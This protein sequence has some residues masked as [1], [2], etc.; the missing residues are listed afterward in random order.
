MIAAQNR[1]FLQHDLHLIGTTLSDNELRDLL[2]LI[3]ANSGRLQDWSGTL[4]L[5]KGS[6]T[7]EESLCGELICDKLI[8]HFKHILRSLQQNALELIIRHYFN[9]IEA[10]FLHSHL[11]WQ[12]LKRIGEGWFAEWPN[13]RRPLSTTWPWNIK[14]SLLV[15]WGVCWMFYGPSGDNRKKSTGNPRGAAFLGEDFRTGHPGGDQSQPSQPS[16]SAGNQ[17]MTFLL[18]VFIQIFLKP[19]LALLQVLVLITHGRTQHEKTWCAALAFVSHTRSQV[20]QIRCLH[21]LRLMCLLI[22]IYLLHR[23]LPQT[24]IRHLQCGLI[25]KAS[26]LDHL[27]H[28]HPLTLLGNRNLL[29][30]QRVWE[31]QRKLQIEE[32]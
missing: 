13:G 32:I 17:I 6:G 27:W 14:P 11:R 30:Q 23:A 22:L 26:T 18:T 19:G 21:H 12:H 7:A 10:Q 31:Q 1:P 8:A 20:T 9:I 29:I 28:T 16:K 5:R 3:C 4:A 2:C 15:L 25:A 24:F